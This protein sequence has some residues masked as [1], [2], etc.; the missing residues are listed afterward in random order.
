MA[1]SPVG[2]A[3][4][5]RSMGE[6][7]AWFSTDADCLDY[8]RWLRWP[9]GFVC[10]ECD[11]AG[12]WEL[13]DSRF[14][15]PECGERTSVTAGTI[16]DRTRTP[17]TVW[18]AACWLFATEKEGISA[19]SLKRALGIGSYQTAW[20]MLHRLRSVLVRPG[21]ERLE[22]VVEVDQSYFGGEERGLAGGRARG[23]R[24]LVGVAVERV[25]PNGFGRCRI[26][27]LPDA[28]GDSLR[29]FLLDN[30][31]EG[32]TVITDGWKSYPPATADLYVH[33]PLEGASGADPSKLLADVHT[34]ASLAKRWLLGTHQGR[35]DDAHLPNYLNEFTFRF[36]HRRSRS[37]GLVFHRVLELAAAHDPVRYRD[38]ILNPR[39]RTA[40]PPQPP[41]SHRRP[42]S[43]DRPPA[44]RPWHAASPP[45]SG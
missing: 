23:K 21:R 27:P 1:T 36:N 35:L 9:D 33:E 45:D 5:P 42:A 13:A 12:A 29:A 34:V 22:G 41:T 6:F 19:L 26:V 14:E 11:H 28:S 18:F 24:V 37:R 25:E 38:L 32:A 8:L 20:A 40:R 44:D 3:H 16:F 31:K 43:L 4:Y 7:Q 39:R 2:G 15:C 17:L 30:V 10:S